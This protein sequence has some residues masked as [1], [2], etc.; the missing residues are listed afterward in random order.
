MLVYLY[1]FLVCGNLLYI[2]K[3]KNSPILALLSV[4]LIIVIMGGNDNNADYEGYKYF[5]SREVQSGSLE[6]GF[7]KLIQLGN[8]LH[9]EYNYFVLSISIICIVILSVIVFK[10]T[11]QYHLVI[12][13]YMLFML[14][15]DTIQIRNF[16]MMTLFYLA[17]EALQNKR[18]ILFLFILF[19]SFLIHFGTLPLFIYFFVK[20]LEQKKSIYPKLIFG[21]VVVIALITFVNGNQIPFINNIANSLLS[22]REDKNVYFN[23][24]TNLGFLT[25]FFLYF[26]NLF[27]VYISYKFVHENSK[28]VD[29]AALKYVDSSYQIALISSFALPLSMM[30]SNFSR[31]IRINNISLYISVAIVVSLLFRGGNSSL[32]SRSILVFNKRISKQTYLVLVFFN[33]FMWIVLKGVPESMIEI[34]RNNIFFR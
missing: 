17:F 28:C 22:G 13:A 12:A 34:I 23:T 9:L 30:N 29:E 14:F 24:R 21:T 27:L 31:Y 6:I 33:L 11:E 4:A 10:H 25:T 8:L 19:L 5:Y 3:K 32:D 18:K 7:V 2:T 15:L 16:I 20:P 26:Y 1:I